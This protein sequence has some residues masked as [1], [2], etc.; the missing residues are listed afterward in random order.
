MKLVR[1]IL[2]FNQCFPNITDKYN[3]PSEHSISV[4]SVNSF[5][6]GEEDLKSLFNRFSRSCSSAEAFV[7]PCDTRL[8][9]VNPS[10]LITL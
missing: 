9:C 5:S 6:P 1:L 2:H 10:S 8:L 3:F 4:M 7:I